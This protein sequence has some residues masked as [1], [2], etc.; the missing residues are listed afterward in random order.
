MESVHATPGKKK[1]QKPILSP[2]EVE[3]I[4][5][6]KEQEAEEKRKRVEEYTQKWREIIERGDNE[7]EDFDNAV[8]ES[9]IFESA[10]V[11]DM[12]SKVGFSGY[13]ETQMLKY[14]PNYDFDLDMMTGDLEWNSS[15]ELAKHFKDEWPHLD[16]IYYY[17]KYVVISSKMEKEIPLMA[18]AYIERL[19]TK[20]GILVNHWNWRRIILTTLIV[21]S[22]VWDDDSLENVHFPKVMHDTSLKEIN[23][24]EKIFLDFIDFDLSI[25]VL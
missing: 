9:G 25:K 1:L 8:I 17:T 20:L 14:H 11:L 19:L 18:L 3:E 23:N 4:K 22:K 21:G 15:F 12:T 16:E 10:E 24:L 6:Q 7:K 2:E 5:K 13:I